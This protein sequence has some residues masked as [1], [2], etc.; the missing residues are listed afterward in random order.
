[1]GW[2]LVSLNVG[3]DL[4]Y[5]KAKYPITYINNVNFTPH[6]WNDINGVPVMSAVRIGESLGTWCICSCLI[7][8]LN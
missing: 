1:M 3:T 7:T 6:T 5:P 8:F 4:L 2:K